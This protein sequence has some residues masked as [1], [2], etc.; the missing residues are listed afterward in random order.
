VQST[1]DA[2]LPV[3]NHEHCREPVQEIQRENKNALALSPLDPRAPMC[4][5]RRAAG[6]HQRTPIWNQTDLVITASN[7]TD[8]MLNH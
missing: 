4:T 6:E 7:A 1:S 3:T 8:H 5:L 2:K